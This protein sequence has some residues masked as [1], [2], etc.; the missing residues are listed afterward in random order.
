MEII[1]RAAEQSA[2]GAFVDA[3]ATLRPVGFHHAGFRQLHADGEAVVGPEFLDE[4]H[5]FSGGSCTTSQRCVPARSTVIRSTCGRS[6]GC[7]A[8]PGVAAPGFFGPRS[9]S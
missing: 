5:S 1:E 3:G 2:H 4:G 9:A 7:A 8:A 6:T